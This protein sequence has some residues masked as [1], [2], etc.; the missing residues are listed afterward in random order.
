MIS[1]IRN[2]NW[3][4]IKSMFNNLIERDKTLYVKECY[5]FF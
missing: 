5:L 2:P 1:R 3:K 4:Y